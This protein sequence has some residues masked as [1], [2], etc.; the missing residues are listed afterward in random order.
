MD[1]QVAAQH[2]ETVNAV[3]A[4]VVK[5]HLFGLPPGT[6]AGIIIQLLPIIEQILAGLGKGATPPAA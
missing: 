4:L 5:D 1:P 2:E 6:I 3:K